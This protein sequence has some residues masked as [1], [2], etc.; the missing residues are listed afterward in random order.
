MLASVVVEK[1]KVYKECKLTATIKYE[2]RP[3]IEKT[4][5]ISRL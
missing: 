1:I 2:D 3:A 5:Y 4:I